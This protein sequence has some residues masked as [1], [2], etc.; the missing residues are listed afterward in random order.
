MRQ[1]TV[2][3]AKAETVSLKH[4]DDLKRLKNYERVLIETAEYVKKELVNVDYLVRMLEKLQTEDLSRTSID[5][6]Y[7][8]NFGFNADRFNRLL[9]NGTV[10]TPE[11]I[12]KLSDFDYEILRRYDY[13]EIN[14][15]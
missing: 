1:E 10:L 5:E 4:E 14:V 3:I 12:K 8:T 13:E 15:L 11:E 2:R 6:F 9:K 7:R